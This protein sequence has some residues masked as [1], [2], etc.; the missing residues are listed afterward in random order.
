[1]NDYLDKL[2]NNTRE[3]HSMNAL[4][5]RLSKNNNSIKDK[6]KTLILS[7]IHHN[8]PN[9]VIN[10]V[11]KNHPGLV[12]EAKNL[13][14]VLARPLKLSPTTPSNFPPYKT[15][16]KLPFKVY[17]NSMHLLNVSSRNLT[18]YN[19]ILRSLG[20]Y[21]DK[22]YHKVNITKNQYLNLHK[23]LAEFK[24]NLPHLTNL[25]INSFAS[26]IKSL[27]KKYKF[28]FTDISLNNNHRLYIYNIPNIQ[29]RTSAL[30]DFSVLLT[31]KNA[32]VRT[33]NAMRLGVYLYILTNINMYIIPVE[34]QLEVYG[35]HI[36]IVNFIVDR[37][38]NIIPKIISAGEI[39]VSPHNI[40]INLLSGTFMR[41]TANIIHLNRY[42]KAST[43]AWLSKKF[44]NKSIVFTKESLIPQMSFNRKQLSSYLNNKQNFVNYFIQR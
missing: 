42:R 37:E 26:N 5:K 25:Q 7:A 38:K 28:K 16:F 23:T 3:R 35:K 36:D 18:Y 11:F 29:T 6:L 40:L 9:R 2:T 14:F 30:D 41:N 22:F 24:S 4:Y 31:Q 15:S 12:F 21:V 13:N 34:N 32:Y 43:L 33:A 17:T 27:L 10:N 20:I 1:M 44:P 8:I 19:R 39:L